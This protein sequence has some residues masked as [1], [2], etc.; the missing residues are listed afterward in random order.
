VEGKEAALAV[1]RDLARGQH[2]S[3][4]DAMVLLVNPI[5]A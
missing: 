2:A 5:S 1:V 3:W 4:L